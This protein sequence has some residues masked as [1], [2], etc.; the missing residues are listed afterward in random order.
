MIKSTSIKRAFINKIIN[1]TD[2]IN[3]GSSQGIDMNIKLFKMD[4]FLG[5]E[6]THNR[7]KS[8]YFSVGKTEE[9]NLTSF[10]TQSN[11]FK[12]KY[13]KKSDSLSNSRVITQ[14]SKSTFQMKKK[15]LVKMLNNGNEK[16]SIFSKNSIIKGDSNKYNSFNKDNKIILQSL[17]VMKNKLNKNNKELYTGNLGNNGFSYLCSS[18]SKPTA[19]SIYFGNSKSKFFI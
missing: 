17:E 5:N 8:N 4:Y 6:Y 2:H 13:H 10:E 11:A 7:S 19:K 16:E 18:N 12:K 15:E 1:E 3:K 9:N 14:E